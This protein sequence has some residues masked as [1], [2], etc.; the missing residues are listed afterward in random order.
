M[1]SL[2]AVGQVYNQTN[3]F[4][5]LGGNVS[6]NTDRGKPAHRPHM[7]QLLEAHPRTVWPTECPLRAQ[8]SDAKSRGARDNDVRL[9]HVEPARVQLRHAA[10]S[11][12]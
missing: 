11:P 8:N 9:R 3:E 5:H 2:E 10:P 12:P 4:V 1:F 6:Q 7:V